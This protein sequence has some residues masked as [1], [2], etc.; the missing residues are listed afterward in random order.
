MMRPD[1]Y[2]DCLN[3]R[4]V[5]VACRTVTTVDRDDARRAGL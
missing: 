5:Y 4:S 1:E 3:R 2:L